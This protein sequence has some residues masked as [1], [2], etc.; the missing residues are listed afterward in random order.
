MKTSF[1]GLNSSRALLRTIYEIEITLRIEIESKEL[2]TPKV[3][4]ARSEGEY[5]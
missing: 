5:E 3:V 1:E 4:V 2:T